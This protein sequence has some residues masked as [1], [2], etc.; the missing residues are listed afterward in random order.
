MGTVSCLHFPRKPHNVFFHRKLFENIDSGRTIVL[1]SCRLS[2]R[3]EVH[4]RIYI[5]T[6]KK[7][8]KS[9][10]C[11]RYWKVIFGNNGLQCVSCKHNSVFPRF[12]LLLVIGFG[13]FYSKIL[14]FFRYFLIF[15]ILYFH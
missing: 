10:I 4:C 11:F 8:P 9:F 5:I 6:R 2:E 12:F 13:F 15:L 1:S 7:A 3:P 14:R